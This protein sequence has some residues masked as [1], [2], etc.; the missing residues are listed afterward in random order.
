MLGWV[1][2]LAFLFPLIYT[3]SSHKKIKRERKKRL[4]MI[5]KRLSEKE[6]AAEKS[7]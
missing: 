5:E 2:I 4:E 1:V 7:D 3:I 6:Q